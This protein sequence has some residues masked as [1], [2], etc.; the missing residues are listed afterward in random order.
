[1]IMNK[2]NIENLLNNRLKDYKSVD[3]FVENL[4]E[5]LFNDIDWVLDGGS[6]LLKEVIRLE[7]V[8]L[9]LIKIF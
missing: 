2:K 9:M 8:F 4:M 1:M 5:D 7:I 6:C 3:S